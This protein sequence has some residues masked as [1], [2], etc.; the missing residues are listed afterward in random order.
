MKKFNNRGVSLIEIL[1]AVVIFVICITPIIN[2]LATG[3]RIGQKADDQ[4]AATDYGRSLAESLKQ[5]DIANAIDLEKGTY[6]RKDLAEL[7][8]LEEDSM[9]VTCTFSSV[10]ADGSAG[11]FIP[12]GSYVI[13]T[14]VKDPGYE[15]INVGTGHGYASVTAMY[16]ELKLKNK[17]AADDAQEALVRQYTIK[18]ES[19]KVD[20]RKYDIVINLD[21]KPYAINS[22]VKADYVD[23]NAINLG[24]LSSLDT[25]KT[26]VI[27]ATSNYDSVAS[28]S[29]FNSAL[30]ALE[31]SE[32]E[33]DR[34]LAVQIKNGVK[35]IESSATKSIQLIL[36]PVSGDPNGYMYKVTCKTIY[37]N[38]GLTSY[39]VASENTTLEYTAFEQR[40]QTFPEIYLMYNQFLY[41]SKYGD[42]IITIENNVDDRE[43]KV[44]VVR[45]AETN[46]AVKDIID[47]DEGTLL[48]PSENKR[49]IIDAGNFKYMTKFELKN[50][51]TAY[52][53]KIFTNIDLER[54]NGGVKVSNISSSSEN[55]DD[56]S[57]KMSINV[58]EA[59]LKDVVHP[60]DED[61]RYSEAGRVY[62]IFIE[63]TNK[64]KNTVT[65]F[66]TSKGDY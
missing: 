47:A 59:Q 37:N 28:A 10:K 4:Q 64:N 55:P 39:G 66:D 8:Q 2:Q 3:I 50:S 7:F 62:N 41:L 46:V 12:N 36:D 15:L 33:E 21:T 57:C 25:K 52:P 42:D 60:L 34:A 54:D 30:S 6:N 31:N 14:G 63:L 18:G 51:L 26:A 32:S 11:V 23:P 16:Q 43:A 20:Y 27:T 17:T 24:N 38:P 44:Y 29:F 22:L 40:F 35:T 58:A 61:E 13:S 53:V 9:D 45:T 65:T 48:P 56:R 5:I 1:I 49:D 19:T